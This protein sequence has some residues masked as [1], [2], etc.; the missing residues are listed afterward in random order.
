M[1]HR[2]GLR[3]SDADRELVAERLRQATADGRL[4]AEELEQRLGTALSARTYGE[5]DAVVS[6]L[7]R[8]RLDRPR[9]ARLRPWI[10]PAVGLAIAIPVAVAIVAAVLFIVTGVLAAWMF[11]AALGWWFFGH[12]RRHHGNRYSRGTGRPTAGYGP[13]RTQARPGLWL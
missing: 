11:W 12:R 4:L 7:P 1:S 10:V 9:Q 2:A 8:G 5:L 3:A 13:R 6:D